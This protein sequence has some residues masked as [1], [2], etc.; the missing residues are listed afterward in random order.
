[1]CAF[2]ALFGINRSGWINL[3]TILRLEESAMHGNIRQE[4]LT[5]CAQTS[6][7]LDCM[8]GSRPWKRFLLT[9]APSFSYLPKGQRWHS[10]STLLRMYIS[11]VNC[12][13]KKW[14]PS[15]EARE[16]ATCPPPHTLPHGRA[17]QDVASKHFLASSVWI[18]SVNKIAPL[19]LLEDWGANSFGSLLSIYSEKVGQVVY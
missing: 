14:K 13:S 17:G 15:L 19:C 2:N 6:P 16:M 4:Q 10:T 18:R 3:V 5:T 12:Y 9:K 11:K 8:S 1:M 7:Q